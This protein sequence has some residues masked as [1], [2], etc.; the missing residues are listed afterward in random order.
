[1]WLMSKKIKAKIVHKTSA[2]SVKMPIKSA[3]WRVFTENLSI[4]SQTAQ[5]AQ[6]G[7]WVSHRLIWLFRFIISS[8]GSAISARYPLP[9]ADCADAAERYMGLTQIDLI[10]QILLFSS[11]IS[12]RYS[13]SSRRCRRCR[14][15]VYGSHSD[16]FD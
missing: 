5:T 11:A 16:W 15:T 3:F 7:I 6:K 9:L 1:M 4:L 8:A 2:K 10:K 14:R 12:A 13:S